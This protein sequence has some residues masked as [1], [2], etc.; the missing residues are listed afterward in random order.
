[1]TSAKFAGQSVE[2]FSGAI[3][4]FCQDVG[5]SCPVGFGFRH[6]ARCQLNQLFELWLRYRR[7]LVPGLK[8][9]FSDPPVMNQP[10]PL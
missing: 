1:V 6:F 9:V 3:A 8:D 5:A 4:A 2:I 10:G 7:L